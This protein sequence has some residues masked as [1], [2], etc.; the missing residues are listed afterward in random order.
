MESD[1]IPVEALKILLVSDIHL[2]Y[3]NVEKMIKWQKEHNAG[4]RYDFVLGSGDFGNIN[5]KVMPED[6]LASNAKEMLLKR[7][8]TREI[9]ERSNEEKAEKDIARVLEIIEKGLPGHPPIYYIP[10]NHDTKAMILDNDIRPTLTLNSVNLHNQWVELRK[11]LA[12]VALGGS[13]PSYFR[14]HGEIEMTSI[15]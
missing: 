11:D 12:L 7:Y 14:K 1:T 13:C 2:A 5:H 3:E 15:Y 9:E 8:E 10:G 6:I 4:V